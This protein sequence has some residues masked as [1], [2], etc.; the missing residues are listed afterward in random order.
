MPQL[1]CISVDDASW[2]NSNW[3]PGSGF[4]FDN[5]TVTFSDD[6]AN[7]NNAT[8]WTGAVNTDWNNPGNWSAKFQTVRMIL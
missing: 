7:F 8:A 5:S 4:Y 2:A 3:G 6:C 1:T